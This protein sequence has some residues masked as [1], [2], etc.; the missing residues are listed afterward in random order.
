MEKFL[1]IVSLL[2]YLLDEKKANTGN[3]ILKFVKKMNAPV[4]NETD[5]TSSRN[6]LEKKVRVY[7]NTILYMA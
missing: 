5:S 3:S 2:E 7:Y 4:P 6:E 1:S